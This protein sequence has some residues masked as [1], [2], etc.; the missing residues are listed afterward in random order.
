[1][2]DYSGIE[3]G[4][5]IDSGIER[6]ELIEEIYRKEAEI[7]RLEEVLRGVGGRPHVCH[8]VRTSR[9]DGTW[10]SMHFE[11]SLAHESAARSAPCGDH[12]LGEPSRA[13]RQLA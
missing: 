2:R 5:L 7:E 9:V 6:G 3:R 10:A 11:T 13:G 8:H 4:E 12:D 1:M